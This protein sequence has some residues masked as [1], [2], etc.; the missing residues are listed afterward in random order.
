[1]TRSTLLLSLLLLG[2]PKTTPA[3]SAPAVE[4]PA[5]DPGE[6]L[7]AFFDEVYQRELAD[8]PIRQ[9]YLGIDQGRGGE[10]TDNT[11]AAQQARHERSV[12][13][14]ERLRATFDPATLSAQDALSYRLFEY[15][16]EREI[17][18]WPYRDHDYPVNQMF[19]THS[20]IPN[21]LIAIHTVSDL[22][23]AEEY[24]QRLEGVPAVMEVA[25]EGLTRREAAGVLPPAFVFPRVLDDCRNLIA[26]APFDDSDTDSALLEDF[27]AKVDGLGLPDEE[28]AALVGRAETLLR[29]QVKPAYEALI[30]VLEDQAT[31]ATTDDGAWKLPDG[32][33]FYQHRLASTTTTDL[34]AETIHQIG[35]DEV[36]RIHAEM[37]A[38]R[39]SVGFE[40][41]LKAFFTHLEE[42]PKF[43]YPDSDEG[44]AEYLAEAKRLIDHMEGR[45][46]E[47][48]FT[49]PKSRIEV[50]A[51]EPWR[52]KSAGK[53]FYQR[54][55]PDGSRPGRYY[56]NLY[57]MA[58]MPIYQMEALA[59]H[60]GIPGHHMQGSISMELQGLPEF[61]KHGGFTAYGE[62]WGLY[63]EFIPKEMGLYEDP[64]SDFGRLAMELW[65]AC[66][67][68]VDTGIHHKQWTRQQAIDYLIENTPNNEGDV[69]KAI[70]RYIVMP[71]Q[72][73]G[74]KIG[75]I[76]ILEIRAKAKEALGDD[77]DIRGF[78]DVVL[79]N[80]PVPL[81]MLEELVD[82]WVA[83]QQGSA[84]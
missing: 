36:A 33:A 76:R 24:L 10:W 1:M 14:L 68:V 19:G 31:R 15:K 29:E 80:G 23:D 83:E 51:V 13:D 57:D 3:P 58:D 46:D 47:L 11:P 44:R 17:A 41:D 64:Y 74:Y 27:R 42:D 79:V 77:F 50:Q 62:G 84:D 8:D 72:T 63:S 66:R 40:G 54:G 20:W 69:V 6:A 71:G 43:Y 28:E 21:F 37:N 75:M 70:E 12:A 9:A 2:C 67:L 25:V 53:A 32:A 61:R 7:A 45:L 34:D 56:A 48:F 49:V 18:G 55:A 81:H 78:H 35:L 59:Y 82:A 38:I 65:R 39:E 22:E 52:E 60:E 5:P 30:A 73:T 16:I 4:V 26:G